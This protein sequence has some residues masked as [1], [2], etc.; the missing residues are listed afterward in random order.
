MTTKMINDKELTNVLYGTGY[1]CLTAPFTKAICRVMTEPAP[2]GMYSHHFK[3][4][5]DFIVTYNAIA[6]SRVEQTND[7]RT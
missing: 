4:Y 5:E 7:R 6:G 3:T 1:P 2:A